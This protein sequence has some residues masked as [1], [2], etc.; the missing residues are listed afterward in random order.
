MREKTE[1]PEAIAMG[2]SRLEGTERNAIVREIHRPLLDVG[3]YKE[4]TNISYPCGD[5]CAS[6]RITRRILKY[7]SC[8]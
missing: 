8:D 5:G 2:I 1:R 7:L 4:M 6:E 3:A